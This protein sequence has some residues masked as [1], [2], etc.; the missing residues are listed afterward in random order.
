MAAALADDFGQ[1]A[2]RIAKFS[3]EF[4]ITQSFIKRVQIRALNILDNGDFER[5][6]VIGLDGQNRHF[7]KA[8][9]LR[10]PPAPLSRDDFISI[11]DA[12]NGPR[13][14]RLNDAFRSDR[15]S[16]FLEFCFVELMARIARIGAQKLN[17]DFLLPPR[18]LHGAGL[19]S[20]FTDQGRQSA[21][22]PGTRFVC[23]GR[24]FH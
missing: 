9:A 7:M 20:R 3:A 12:G 13:Q 14:D 22:E 18:A 1:I 15:I 4:F 16:Q 19:F 2:L 6:L 23:H 10:R 5:L 11:R 17:W 24:G 8:G 21:T